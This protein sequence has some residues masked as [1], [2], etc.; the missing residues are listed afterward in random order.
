M[1]RL[2]E[3]GQEVTA[4]RDRSYFKSYFKTPGGLLFEIVTDTPGFAIGDTVEKLGC[5]LALPAQYEPLS[6]DIEAHL[7]PLQD[8]LVKKRY[9]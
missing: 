9:E 3:N 7:P 8:A 4:V 2:R 6:A 5:K 1:A